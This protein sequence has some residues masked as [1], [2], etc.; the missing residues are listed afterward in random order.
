[1]KNPSQK[2]NRVWWTLLAAPILFFV[3]IIVASIYFGIVNG[4]RIHAIS[5]GGSANLVADDSVQI[6]EA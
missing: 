1:M 2:F 4:R 3:G 5:T 6:H